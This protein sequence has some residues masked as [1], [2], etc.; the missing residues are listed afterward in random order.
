MGMRGLGHPGSWG[1]GG[2]KRALEKEDGRN[3]LSKR[4]ANK[5]GGFSGIKGK[6][7]DGKGG[8]TLAMKKLNNNANAPLTVTK[9]SQMYWGALI[10]TAF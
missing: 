2:N 7:R 8:Q 9:M 4:P 5:R 6:V 1:G 3:I 10:K